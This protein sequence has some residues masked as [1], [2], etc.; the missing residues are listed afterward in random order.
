M[1]HLTDPQGYVPARD[2]QFGEVRGRTLESVRAGACLRGFRAALPP[3]G[4]DRKE[5]KTR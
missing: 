1:Q 4:K 5:G 2:D 3:A